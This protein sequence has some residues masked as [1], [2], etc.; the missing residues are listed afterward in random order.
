MFLALLPPRLATAQELKLDAELL[1]G[2]FE[3]GLKYFILPNNNPQKEIEL[4]LV[5]KTGSLCEED[6][7]QGMAHFVEHM[8]FNGTKNF[9]G[10]EVISYLESKGMRFGRHFNALTG[11]TETIFMLT[12]TDPDEDLLGKSFQILE[13][14]AHQVSFEDIEIEKERGVI[15]Q[16]LRT[17]LN[18]ESRLRDAYFPAIF[19]G[20]KYQYRLPIGKAVVLESF[21]PEQLRAFYHKWYRPERM[22]VIVTGDIDPRQAMESVRSRFEPIRNNHPVPP[23][24]PYGVPDN[25]SPV[26]CLA[27][28]K[29]A[30][31]DMIRMFF[32]NE[33][34]K[35]LSAEDLHTFVAQEL[36]VAMIS[37]RLDE[38]NL[39]TA[40]P[41]VF[42]QAGLGS[43]VR[44]KE[45][46]SYSAASK[47][48]KLPEAINV[49]LTEN[50]R[51]LLHGFIDEEL[52]LQKKI[53][54]K[55]ISVALAE[56]RDSKILAEE[57]T[58]CFLNDEPYFNFTQL[59]NLKTETITGISLSEINQRLHFWL[60]KE[61]I[62]IA[63][64]T[65][66]LA[67][68]ALAGNGLETMYQTLLTSSPE[69]RKSTDSGNELELPIA[70]PG[71]VVEEKFLEEYGITEWKLS[72]GATVVLKPT[73]FE[74]N[75]VLFTAVSP[76]GT[77]QYPDNE[78]ITAALSTRVA[79]MSGLGTMDYNQ[80]RSFLQKEGVRLA[81]WINDFSEGTRGSTDTEGIEA[82]LKLNYLYFTALK[83]DSV[84]AVSYLSRL[85]SQLESMRNDPI[86]VL[87]DT[88]YKT[89]YGQKSR[90][91]ALSGPERL[92]EFDLE[93]A[94]EIIRE[95][96]SD[97]SGFSFVFVGNFEP[98][99]IRPLAEKYI[100]SLNGPSGNE[101]IPKEAYF[102][103]KK[104]KDITV[105]SGLAEKSNV[106]LTYFGEIPWTQKNRHTAKVMTEVL[107]IELRKALRE[108]KGGVYGISVSSAFEDLPEPWFEFDVFFECSTEMVDTLLHELEAQIQQIIRNGPSAEVMNNVKSV[109]AAEYAQNEK[110]NRFWQDGLADIYGFNRTLSDEITGY[111]PGISAVTPRDVQKLAKKTLKT[112]RLVTAKMYPA[113]KQV[114]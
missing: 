113:E 88:V 102:A 112:N 86:T 74:N 63:T 77:A 61:P 53:K 76:G 15:L 79:Y 38:I 103:V 75:E 51:L 17:G 81:A 73:D 24:P 96:F 26:F 111:L 4:R 19:R 110:K 29:E 108:E 98:E 14:W 60:G 83:A 92:N 72:N 7:E 30:S 9:P 6:S 12:L 21:K 101:T 42:S 99:R 89:L 56:K 71:S 50:R 43:L 100:G 33:A 54:A 64:M 93:R 97:P 85:R 23:E 67:F 104:S 11:F 20:A 18:A 68:P 49:L 84:A 22:A 37:K 107:R 41:F 87:A 16:E 47:V 62:I 40:S 5:I 69:A 57:L 114:E 31:R 27:A 35:M 105:Y 39:S 82:L 90:K 91:L 66:S 70:N 34:E 1:S 95:R 78:Y 80:L 3:N 58:D 109:I 106:S 46:F 94:N 13:D 8:C 28:D 2:T 45:A 52:D 65:D 32:L 55:E 59:M 36:A 44:G 10:N 25:T 48:G